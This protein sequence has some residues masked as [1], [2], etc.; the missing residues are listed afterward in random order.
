MEVEVYIRQSELPLHQYYKLWGDSVDFIYVTKI[1]SAPWNAIRCE[2]SNVIDVVTHHKQHK[3]RRVLHKTLPGFP[4]TQFKATALS[5]LS[6]ALTSIC[7]LPV[8]SAFGSS[9]NFVS[10]HIPLLI[11]FD[12]EYFFTLKFQ[13]CNLSS[14]NFYPT[15]KIKLAQE[16]YIRGPN[17]DPCGTPVDKPR[18]FDW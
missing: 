6:P 15:M 10:W 3:P 8:N 11:Y 5:V 18:T 13:V 16:L 1:N 2:A 14:P 17:I 4:D 12:P 9:V 7:F